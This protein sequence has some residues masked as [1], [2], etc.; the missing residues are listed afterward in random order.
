MR[1]EAKKEEFHQKKEIKIKKDI[2]F[3]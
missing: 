3:L 1:Q 2:V